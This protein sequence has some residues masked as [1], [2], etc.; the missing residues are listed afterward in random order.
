MVDLFPLLAQA[1][2]E[3]G[4][5][6]TEFLVV[7]G[8]VLTP[9]KCVGFCGTALFAGRWIVQWMATRRAGRV[10]MPTLFW[11]MS[12]SGSLMLMAY[13]VFGK[14]DA[15]GVLSNLFPAFV[16]CYNL[17]LEARRRPSITVTATTTGAVS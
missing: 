2:P 1:R 6:N 7:S 5:M 3:G 9:W 16:S 4:W 14:N 15:V 13:F 11:Y 10:V 17:V 8:V 12:V